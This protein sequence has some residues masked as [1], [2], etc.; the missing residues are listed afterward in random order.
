[1]MV[2]RLRRKEYSGIHMTRMKI[3]VAT[4]LGAILLVGVCAYV[5]PMTS[6]C[7]TAQAGVL[8][9]MHDTSALSFWQHAIVLSRR[10]AELAVFAFAILVVWFVVGKWRDHMVRFWHALPHYLMLLPPSRLQELFSQG[11]LH[12]KIY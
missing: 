12:P 5:Q 9:P 4:L 3:L 7:P 1:M 6:D 8:C 11:I 10:V 2:C